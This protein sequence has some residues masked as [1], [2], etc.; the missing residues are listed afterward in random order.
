MAFAI[1]VE[2]LDLTDKRHQEQLAGEVMEPFT[3]PIPTP[4]HMTTSL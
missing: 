3:S 4:R 1:I 2:A